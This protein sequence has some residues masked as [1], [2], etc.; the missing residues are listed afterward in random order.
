[1]SSTPTLSLSLSL[2]LSPHTHLET[3]SLTYS[4]ICKHSLTHSPSSDSADTKTRNLPNTHSL[5]LSLSLSLILSLF[6]IR[7]Q[8]L[9]QFS[10][11]KI[12]KGRRGGRWRKKLFHLVQDKTKQSI[13][14]SRCGMNTILKSFR[15]RTT[16]R[17][18]TFRRYVDSIVERVSLFLLHLASQWVMMSLSILYTILKV[19]QTGSGCGSVG[20]AVAFNTRGPLFESSHRQ[21]LY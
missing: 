7:L 15:R 5:S 21:N 20:R 17:Q 9:H 12:K 8:C 13:R 18:K 19:I 16:D 14:H 2:S 3:F 10:R 11:R 4:Y 6:L 1:M